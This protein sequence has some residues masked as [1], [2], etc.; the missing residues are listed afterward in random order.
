MITLRKKALLAAVGAAAMLF[1]AQSFALSLT[2]ADMTCSGTPTKPQDKVFLSEICGVTGLSLDYKNDGNE[3]GSFADSYSVAYFNTPSD[4][5]DATIT[6]DGIT[7]ISCPTC[8]LVV[9]DGN[10]FPQFYG[11]NLGSWD[12]KETITLTGFWP[13]QGSIS[14]VSIWTDGS[15]QDVPEPGSLALLGLGLMALGASRRRKIA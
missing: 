1:G 13:R 15:D 14:H 5:S 8:W 7:A 6:W 4:P 11:Y 9:K 2:P 3:S 10:N 12:G